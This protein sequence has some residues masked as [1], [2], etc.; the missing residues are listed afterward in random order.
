MVI[1]AGIEKKI[2]TGMITSTEFLKEIQ[3]ILTEDSLQLPMT[4]QVGKWCSEYYRRYQ[5]APE[6]HIQDIFKRKSKNLKDE[7]RFLTE[8]FLDR[9][10]KKYK[11]LKT[12]NVNYVLNEAKEYFKLGYFDNIRNK[13]STALEKGNIEK[14][15]KLFTDFKSPK[16][17]DN[18]E[19]VFKDGITASE[20][21]NMTLQEVKWLIEGI[22]PKGLTLL[23]GKAKVGK[24]YF[25]LNLALDLSAGRK[26]FNVI[27]TEPSKVLYL[28]L[29]EPKMRTKTR[30]ESIIGDGEWPENLH[31]FGLGAWPK[32]DEGGYDRL[33]LWMKEHPDTELIIIDTLAKW[34]SPKKKTNRT[35]YEEEYQS[36]EKLHT[37]AG[38][39]DIAV[40]V[41]HH[42]RKTQAEDIM[43]E[44]IGGTG[45]QASV[46][47]IT[48][49]SRNKRVDKDSRIYNYRGRDIGEGERVFKFKKNS[50]MVLTD[51]NVSDYRMETEQ[52]KL[53]QK[54]V[55]IYRIIKRKK[56]VDLLQGQIGKGIDVILRKMVD[57]GL[58]ERSGYGKYAY[59]GYA[60]DK[61][62][63]EMLN[64]QDWG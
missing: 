18:P 43:D 55:G 45:I 11:T 31:I 9:L 52:R 29:E 12:F 60:K 35:E 47:T 63:Q 37:F 51:E 15:E 3:P 20:L 49:I 23:A 25:L 56:L 42:A 50:R 6:K 53:I 38:N 10:S 13:L 48:I 2:I 41:A 14:A 46:D 61:R 54:V 34:K 8:E 28:G 32:S 19:D 27:L 59:K 62:I 5:Q 22:V 36:L 1:D 58:I 24:S 39:H 33:E 21:K 44:I 40:I 7:Q 4:K 57:T 26:A 64:S 16:L 30:I 17:T